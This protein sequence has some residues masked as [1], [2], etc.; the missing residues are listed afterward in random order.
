ML[1]ENAFKVYMENIRAAIAF[2]LLLLFV[3]VFLLEFFQSQNLFFSS[4]SFFV[5]YSLA[6]P[7]AI[8]LELGVAALYLILFSFFVSLMVFGVRK[9]LSKVRVEYY[10][11]EMVQKF[12]VQIFLFFLLYC[13]LLS[14]IGLLAVLTLEPLTGMY[15][16]SLVMMMVSLLFMFV[17]QAIVIDEVGV[18]DALRESLEFISKN[19]KSFFTVI[20]AGA[21]LLAVVILI[22][23]LLDF[24]LLDVLIG[25]FVSVLLLFVFVVP[26]IE[27][28]KTYAYMLKFDL[29]KKSELTKNQK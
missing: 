19:P 13:T 2:G 7:E 29:V 17:P 12:T 6:S 1:L 22:E 11:S 16:A 27:A 9:D 21:A 23:F 15:A 4:G 28:V 24:L 20:V 5:E 3:P 25:R 18:I 26:Y 10:L 8:A 14:A